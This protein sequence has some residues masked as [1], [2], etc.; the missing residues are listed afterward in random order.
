MIVAGWLAGEC[1]GAD[2][3]SL[4]GWPIPEQPLLVLGPAGDPGGAASARIEGNFLDGTW[5]LETVGAGPP[6]LPEVLLVDWKATCRA[7]VTR[8]LVAR[9]TL[10]DDHRAAPPWT[11]TRRVLELDLGACPSDGMW[12]FGLASS[13]VVVTP[14]D[15]GADAP[16]EIVAQLP[17]G[18]TPT[19]R[20]AGTELDARTWY[21]IDSDHHPYVVRDGRLQALALDRLAWRLQTGGTTWVFGQTAFPEPRRFLADLSADPFAPTVFQGPDPEW[22][23]AV[24]QAE[25]AVRERMRTREQREDRH[26]LAVAV[27]VAAGT[28][29]AGALLGGLVAAV[30]GRP[31]ARGAALGAGTAVVAATAVVAGLTA[32]ALLFA[33]QVTREQGGW[34][35]FDFGDPWA[36]TACGGL[37][38]LTSTALVAFLGSLAAGRPGPFRRAALG[39]ALGASTVLHLGWVVAA[40]DAGWRAVAAAAWLVTNGC[41]VGVAWL[42]SRAPAG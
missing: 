5:A 9:L 28:P 18:P 39:I 11:R 33:A 20:I 27:G 19:V 1:R 35:S 10:E 6:T 41:A 8:E 24:Q 29:L 37:A 2:P 32:P 30:R 26:E 13:D 12:M 31:I 42:A 38:A 23:R 40:P 21:A 17:V 22:D 25:D 16:P 36:L 7:P 14:V 4:V 3:A 15:G 34:L